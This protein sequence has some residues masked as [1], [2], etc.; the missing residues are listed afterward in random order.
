MYSG[1]RSKQAMERRKQK[2]EVTRYAFQTSFHDKIIKEIVC[3]QTPENIDNHLKT[4]LVAEPQVYFA[5]NGGWQDGLVLVSSLTF[6]V[7]Q[8]MINLPHDPIWKLKD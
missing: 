4:F 6:E 3:T 2:Y 8:N 5:S 7:Y 1:K